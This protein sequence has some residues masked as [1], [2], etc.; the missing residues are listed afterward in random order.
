M[1][2]ELRL[3][4]TSL[5]LWGMG[6]GLFFYFQ[7]L[8]L[9]Q[10]G[11]SPVQ[12][13]GILGLAS[14]GLVI[15]HIPAGALAD[16]F[17]RRILMLAASCLGTI[18]TWIMF[19]APS[20]TFFV[21]GLVLYYFTGFIMSPMSSYVTAARGE[22]TVARALTTIWASLSVGSIL[23]PII[24]GQLS[25]LIGLRAIYGVSASLFIFST[26]VMIFLPAQP[27]EP[28]SLRIG[29]RRLLANKPFG[30]LLALF[31]FA[32]F[33]LLLSW[34]LL[35]TFLQNV[36]GVSV[37]SIGIFG[38]F[39]ALGGMVLSLALGRMS[40]RPAF[41]LAQG[42]VLG[43]A[44]VLWLGTGSPWF[45]LGYFLIGGY[46]AARALMTALAEKLV[47]KPQMGLAFGLVETSSG[48]AL[49][50]AAPLAGLLY[51]S[52]PYLPF[53]VSL[54]LISVSLTINGRL[55]PRPKLTSDSIVPGRE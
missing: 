10:L 40:N 18:A 32:N 1:N 3:V 41:L 14:I 45:A 46:R 4:A 25:K 13:G 21:A 29:Y 39:N 23:G 27:R 55:L 36:R 22:W 5:L 19:L 17:G 47:E 33:G 20:L 6:E 51:R 49:L 30:R 7:P 44:T 24:G 53:P 8:Y 28:M 50:A 16:R 42:L 2:R 38:S 26:A 15:T 11:A 34:P 52:A 37:E 9:E 31:L 48:L 35:P 43:S 54:I 12:I